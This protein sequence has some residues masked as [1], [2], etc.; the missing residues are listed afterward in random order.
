MGENSSEKPNPVSRR[1]FL[2]WTGRAAV[3]AV[4]TSIAGSVPQIESKEKINQLSGP[5]QIDF[6]PNFNNEQLARR[7]LGD[8]YKSLDELE[9]ESLMNMKYGEEFESWAVRNYPEAA[10]FQ[11]YIARFKDHGSEVAQ[12]MKEGGKLL[13]KSI[14]PTI[15][16][17]QNLIRPENITFSTDE[18]EN[19]GISVNLEPQPII[20][21]IKKIRL[22]S[23][24]QR[25]VN[26]SLL[27]GRMEIW[28]SPL[29]DPYPNKPFIASS[30]DENG[31]RVYNVNNKPFET[32]EE[33]WGEWRRLMMDYNQT[34]EGKNLGTRRVEP[35]TKERIGENFPK[36][37]EIAK[38]F[39][40]MVIC[41]ATGNALDDLRSVKD[42][43]PPNL[44]ILADWDPKENKP[45]FNIPGADIYIPYQE[46]TEG[47]G[48]SLATG[49]T[50]A[51]VSELLNRGVGINEVKSKLL[52]MCRSSNW[53]LSEEFT[54]IA[55][56]LDLKKLK[57]CKGESLTSS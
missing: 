46:V 4:A 31:N 14:E 37:V 15:I 17:V 44:I 54:E 53:K 21:A 29:T 20:E 11:D 6:A 43:I 49:F 25:V 10:L 24:N 51:I 42:Q 50:S 47:A 1:D 55:R 3:V 13:G 40:D 41:A 56:V 22:N 57:E 39:P 48:S 30:T 18:W 32:Q 9:Y 5:I 38:A 27:M 34:G 35:Y 2:K 36:L 8:K 52:G 45:V 28:K 26:L 16:P 19:A 7:F 23:S 33:A 12:A